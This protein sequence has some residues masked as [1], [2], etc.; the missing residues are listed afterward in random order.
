MPW[1]APSASFNH[2]PLE[3]PM[4]FDVHTVS[5]MSG[6][7]PLAQSD[8]LLLFMEYGIA[9][10]AGSGAGASV[11]VDVAVTDPLPAKYFVDVELDQDATAYITN[12][13]ALGFTVNL[14]PRLATATLAAGAFNVR[15]TA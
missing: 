15:V 12:K 2:I 14:Q 8:R 10:G 7:S 1:D 5:V 13:T 3:I 11:A 4:S 9:N 6:G